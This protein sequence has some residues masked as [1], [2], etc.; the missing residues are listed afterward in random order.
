MSERDERDDEDEAEERAAAGGEELERAWTLLEA[1]DVAGAR[2]LG[3]GLRRAAPDAPEPAILL[4]ACARVAGDDEA[5]LSLLREAAELDPEWAEPEL[6]AAEI[7]A[8]DPDTSDEALRAVTRAVEKAEEEDELLDAIAL[9][10]G[11]ELEL[12]RVAAARRTL[13]QL[14]PAEAAHVAPELG[15]ELGHIYLAVDDPA[16]A[17]RWLERALAE[18]RDDADTWHALGLVAEAEDDEPGKRRAWLRTLE[19]DARADARTPLR[20]SE[21]QMGEVAEQALAELPGRARQLLANV[22]ILIAD[23]PSREDVAEGLDPRLLGL[24]TGDAYPDSSSLG[25][26]PQLTQILLFRHNLERVAE[27]EAELREEIRTTLLHET[28]HFFGM[29]EDDLDEVGLG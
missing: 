4:A 26:Q 12:E 3:E 13:T 2:S 18:D 5:A 19:L 24:F 9:K 11:L 17:R 8:D 29:D 7:L 21:A 6:R 25:G 28:G 14:P 27:D 16:S 22:P 20:L 15:R 23:R 10:A 1:A